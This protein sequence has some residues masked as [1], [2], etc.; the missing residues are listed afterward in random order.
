[1]F[2]LFGSKAVDAVINIVT[3]ICGYCGVAADQRITK[4]ATKLTLFFVPLF[5][6]KSS[7]FNEC[8]NCGGITP[9]TAAQ[10]DHSVEWARTHPAA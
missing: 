5:S 3:F 10:A 1:V 7:Y 6:L 9:L 4:R 2:L 8:A